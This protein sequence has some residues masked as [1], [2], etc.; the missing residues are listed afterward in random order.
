MRC[1]RKDSSASLPFVV[2]ALL[3]H[4]A[5]ADAS[6]NE[7]LRDKMLTYSVFQPFISVLWGGMR[8]R[9]IF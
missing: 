6:A 2:R 1:S 9:T 5:E 3:A 7:D 4:L 8:L